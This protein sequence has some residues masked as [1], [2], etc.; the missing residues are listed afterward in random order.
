MKSFS[1]RSS[2]L[3]AFL[4]VVVF[5]HASAAEQGDAGKAFLDKQDLFEAN[6]GGYFIY[7]IPGIVATAK[8][9]LLAYCEARQG[10]GNDWD[11]IDILMRRSSDG[12]KTW[13]P[14]RRVVEP[15][16]K[17]EENPA[18]VKQKLGLGQLTLHNPVAF[19]DRQPGVVHFLYGVEYARY[20]YLRSDNDGETFAAPVDITPTLEK[21]RK[22]YAWQACGVGPGHGIQLKTG[23]LLVPVWL[24]TG[25]GGN[26]HRPSC[27]A[28]IYSDDGGKTWQRGAIVASNPDPAVNPNETVAIELA[29]GRVLLN[30]RHEGFKGKFFRAI[31]IS[32]DGISGWSALK[33][34]EQLPETVCMAS[35]VRH[36]LPTAAKKGMI[37]FANPHN[38]GS[39]VRKNLTVKSSADECQTW[40]AGKV[41]EPGFSGYSDMTVGPDGTIYCL[42]ERG[43]LSNSSFQTKSLCLARFNLAWLMQ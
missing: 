22:D 18:A 40:S 42:Y 1:V 8:G 32:P 26:A 4:G 38:L 36:T 21:F 12:G 29:D 25:E 20:Y 2:L 11:R 33:L 39:R 35:L 19:A 23:R 9:T 31:A 17:W 28:T 24:S 14:A 16:A 6:T 27:M 15:P 13:T 34:D 5:M 7:R 30:I 43:R 10:K 41:L 3:V 37:L